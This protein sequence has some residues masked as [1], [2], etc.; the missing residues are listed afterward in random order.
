MQPA[1]YLNLDQVI[2]A[3]LKEQAALTAPVEDCPDTPDVPLSYLQ[4]AHLIERRFGWDKKDH[5]LSS[6]TDSPVQQHHSSWFTLRSALHATGNFHIISAAAAHGPA[7]LTPQ[8]EREAAASAAASASA[9]AATSEKHEKASPE[10]GANA[11]IIV[12]EATPVT[13]FVAKLVQEHHHRT[14]TTL[15]NS[16][17][18]DSTAS[19]DH[20]KY[21]AY[22]VS[23]QIPRRK[24]L[25][26][27]TTLPIAPKLQYPLVVAKEDAKTA[28]EKAN[29]KEFHDRYHG[30]IFHDSSRNLIWQDTEDMILGTM[31]PAE[32]NILHHRSDMRWAGKTLNMFRPW[33]AAR[34]EDVID[35]FLH[36][37]RPQQSP[38]SSPPSRPVSCPGT[39]GS[40]SAKNSPGRGTTLS[41]IDSGD[42]SIGG[43]SARI[44]RSGGGKRNAA[45]G[46][47]SV[48]GG[49]TVTFSV[50]SKQS[51]STPQARKTSASPPIQRKHHNTAPHDHD[52]H[53]NGAHYVEQSDNV[54]VLTNNSS[55]MHYSVSGNSRSTA[56][57]RRTPLLVNIVKPV[58]VATATTPSTPI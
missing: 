22:K 39:P 8:E 42:C 13:E 16:S 40:L 21:P 25:E 54:S 12:V 48:S 53:H 47:S 27:T 7:T 43:G 37:K 30:L 10:P 3:S 46:R 14:T 45:A 23:T 35:Q 17:D 20:H 55:V 6:K 11:P 9:S 31:K 52:T 33:S 50:N 41:R 36:Q 18:E 32:D 34:Q 28:K 56:M 29:T 2:E 49:S 19:P 5:S 26:K 24:S 4:S 51:R 1:S 38:P 57:S 44:S 15:P 58:S